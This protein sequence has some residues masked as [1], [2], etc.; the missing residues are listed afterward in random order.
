MFDVEGVESADCF[1]H[2]LEGGGEGAEEVLDW[3]FG[4]EGASAERE[5]W[6]RY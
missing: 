2:E 6:V 5:V 4:E 1:S 3:S